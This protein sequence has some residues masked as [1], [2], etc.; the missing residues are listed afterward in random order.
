MNY[1]PAVLA[2]EPLTP[3]LVEDCGHFSVWNKPAGMLCQ[4]S[5]WSDHTTLYRWAEIHLSPQ[6]PSFLI[7]RLDRMTS[8]LTVL[9]HNKKVAAYL[10]AQFETG[11]LVHYR[12][13]VEGIASCH[14][15]IQSIY[16]WMVSPA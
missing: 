5:R 3:S 16:R 11:K 2:L 8:G 13:V 15:L 12:V 4:G 9:A 1:N 7:H 14:C 10:A 6:R